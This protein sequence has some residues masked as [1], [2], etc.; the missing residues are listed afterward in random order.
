M[1]SNRGPP[2]TK[3]IGGI[4]S[5]AMIVNQIDPTIYFHPSASANVLCQFDMANKMGYRI[6]LT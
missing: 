5:E 6:E 4:V 1:M 3:K 2:L